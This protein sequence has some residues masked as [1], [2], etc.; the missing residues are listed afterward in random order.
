MA[1]SARFARDEDGNTVLKVLLPFLENSNGRKIK[2]FFFRDGSIELR[3][4]EIPDFESLL[5]DTGFLD[6]KNVA[7]WLTK[8]VAKNDGD[9]FEYTVR[10]AVEPRVRGKKREPAGKTG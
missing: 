7:S 2:I 10:R 4:A 5:G 8:L 3:L 1:A 9:I 6:N